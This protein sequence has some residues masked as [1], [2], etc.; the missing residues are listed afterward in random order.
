[1]SADDLDF[2]LENHPPCKALELSLAI[3]LVSHPDFLEPFTPKLARK[4]PFA[5]HFLW[6]ILPRRPQFFAN[7]CG[8]VYAA[9]PDDTRLAFLF[10]SACVADDEPD[11]ALSA[12]PLLL[13]A[14]W[15]CPFACLAMSRLFLRLSRFEDSFDCLNACCYA[16]QF[17]EAAQPAISLPATM[18]SRH[19][20]SGSPS[21]ME[22]EV[23]ASQ[24]FGVAFWLTRVTGEVVQRVMPKQFRSM[25]AGRFRATDETDRA[26]EAGSIPGSRIE[27]VEDSEQLFD[28]GVE[29][30]LTVPN[31]VK[32]LPLCQRFATVATDVLEYV[33]QAEQARKA[34]HIEQDEAEDLG[35][36]ALRI[37]D[38]G[39]FEVVEKIL[40]KSKQ[41]AL[42]CELVRARLNGP[43]AWAA[44]GKAKEVKG[45]T[46]S[47]S[48]F[49]TLTLFRAM[50]DGMS[51]WSA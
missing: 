48:E 42:F 4:F 14:M 22:N 2:L 6:Q 35:M 47:A 43:K 13:N 21:A 29:G 15:C 33:N 51:T 36:L 46:M 27:S 49:A 26:I 17:S 7:A 16:R 5:L 31:F 9:R 39:L 45:K 10:V 37:E 3:F 23:L 41:F 32:Q 11:R 38:F 44:I 1:M 28:P 34:K 24:Q 8:A 25:L 12:V 18:Q 30:E 50:A 40:K 19:C 20:P